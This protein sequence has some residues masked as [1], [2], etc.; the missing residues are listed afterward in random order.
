MEYPYYY[1]QQPPE[2]NDNKRQRGSYVIVA[3]IFTIVGALLAT[4]FMPAMY[5]QG[6][7]YQDGNL[8]PTATPY[9]TPGGAIPG[10]PELP[11]G[12]PAPTNPQA[13]TPAPTT[14]PLPD[15]DGTPPT[16]G[17]S[18]GG[19]YNPIPDIVEQVT[20]GVVSVIN[21]TYDTWFKM[22]RETSTGSGFIISSDG[23]IVTNAHV[24][25]GASKI[26]VVLSDGTEL[27]AEI[28]GY[29][30][31][32]TDVAVI[33]VNATGLNALSIGDSDTVRVGDFVIAI[34]DPTGLELAGSTTYGIVSAMQ[35][36]VN[37]DGRT[38]T[39]LQTDAAL[40]PGNS[41]GP[42]FNMS[43]EVIGINTAKTVTASYDEEGGAISAEG[44]GFAI[45][46]NDAMSV[47]TQL[48]TNGQIQRPG[49]GINVL[50]LDEYA[51]TEY[52]VPQG[53]MVYSVTLDGP[54]YNAGLK[55]NDIIV[56]FDGTMVPTQAEFVQIVQSKA[57]GDEIKFKVWRA[58]E[59]FEASII[60][61]DLNSL[62][63]EKAYG[64]DADYDFFNEN[65][66]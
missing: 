11:E 31:A 39:Y 7:N 55:P 1:E 24:I 43:G 66:G 36:S 8:S 18:T 9:Y 38:N 17:E 6:N 57:V 41:G 5:N 35:R 61:G 51:A 27:E 50:E 4:I 20:S 29:D 42:L 30:K 40:N 65:K 19:L 21:S 59:Y 46:V 63:N 33:K 25:E 53:I 62:G 45:P 26:T 54:G 64:G 28:I 14:R 48:I 44:L 10:M 49:V 15:F 3:V 47:V 16:L 22:D 58:G 32:S 23:Y 52:G 2:E 34:G 56:E 37:I 12:T 60:L 13:S